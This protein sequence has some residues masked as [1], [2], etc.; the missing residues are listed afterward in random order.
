M[1]INTFILNTKKKI[2]GIG[3]ALY[4]FKLQLLFR[5]FGNGNVL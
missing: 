4:K 3:I 1:R 2:V 5:N